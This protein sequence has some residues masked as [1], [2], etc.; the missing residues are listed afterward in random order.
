MN[1]A[2]EMLSVVGGGGEISAYF[3]DTMHSQNRN[4]FIIFD[5]SG[6]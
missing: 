4:N 3:G 2:C 5:F 1:T 6:H